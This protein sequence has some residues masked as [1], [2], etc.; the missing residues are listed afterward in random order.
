M[1]RALE[2][3]PQVSGA[4]TIMRALGMLNEN[5]PRKLVRANHL[6]TR[7]EHVPSIASVVNWFERDQWEK[8]IAYADAS[9]Y[10]P[11]LLPSASGA[12]GTIACFGRE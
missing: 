5:P 11:S 2:V 8:I 10:S 1:P 3:D 12:L 6:Y 9:Q 7:P 4:K